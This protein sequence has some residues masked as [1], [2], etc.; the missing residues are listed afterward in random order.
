M[1]RTRKA[2]PGPAAPSALAPEPGDLE[3]GH[4]DKEPT[5]GTV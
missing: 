1:R 5:E 2:K 3:S 4:E